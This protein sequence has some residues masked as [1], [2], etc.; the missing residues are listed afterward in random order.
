MTFKEYRKNKKAIDQKRLTLALHTRDDSY[1]PLVFTHKNKEIE[2]YIEYYAYEKARQLID[3]EKRQS[4]AN[5]QPDN[6]GGFEFVERAIRTVTPAGVIHYIA[7][8]LKDCETI[9][10]VKT[11]I[12]NFWNK[13]KISKMSILGKKVKDFKGKKMKFALRDGS[14]F[15][16]PSYRDFKHNGNPVEWLRELINES[17]HVGTERYD[18]HTYGVSG[19]S[20]HRGDFS[21]VKGKYYLVIKTSKTGTLISHIN[22]EDVRKVHVTEKFYLIT[23]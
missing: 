12:D 19:S 4:R 11:L 21:P 10:E 18:S 22:G 5:Y 20:N 7:E 13:K 3:V 2:V 15:F 1:I 6:T 16:Y 14:F 23:E 17:T 9:E 8:E